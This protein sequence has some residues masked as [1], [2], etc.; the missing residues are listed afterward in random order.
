MCC[1]GLFVVFFFSFFLLIG[2]KEKSIINKE[3]KKKREQ[4][5]QKLVPHQPIHKTFLRDATIR[6]CIYYTHTHQLTFF[7]NLYD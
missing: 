2:E 7:S 6:P 1:I 3:K 4:F 5:V